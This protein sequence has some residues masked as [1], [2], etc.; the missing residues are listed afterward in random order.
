MKKIL[1]LVTIAASVMCACDNSKHSNDIPEIGDYS[2]KKNWLNA[3]ENAEQAVDVFYV[4]PTVIETN[5]KYCGMDDTVMTKEAIK[6]YDAYKDIF[7][8]CNFYAP[9]YHQLSIDYISKQKTTK[10]VE[11][12]IDEIP[13]RDCKAAFEYYL[14]HFNNN[15]PIIFAGHSQ[16]SM[17]LKQLLLWVKDEHPEVFDRTIA[18]YL[19]GFAVN[20]EYLDKVELPFAEGRNDLGVVISYNTEAPEA[21]PS[22]FTMNLY[23]DCMVINPINWK[24]DET[25]APKEESL[26][27]RLRP[28]DEPTGD[29]PHFASAVCNLTRG[30]VVTDAPVSSGTFWPKGCLHHFDFD[31]F[32]YDLKQN[33][34]DRIDAYNQL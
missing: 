31:L 33:V 8:T 28:E 4:Y 7:E 5:V 2:I 18:A 9:F 21:D 20:Q 14:T 15:R 32:Y 13:A 23:K 29:Q 16:G 17:I 25:P 24:R 10:A 1:L 34:A 22:P 12:A 11:A 3:P 19:I 6:L 26:G 30:T 27:S